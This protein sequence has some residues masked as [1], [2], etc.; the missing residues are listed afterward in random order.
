MNNCYNYI[1]SEKKRNGSDS[2]SSESDQETK[3]VLEYRKKHQVT[4][5]KGLGMYVLKIE[6]LVNQQRQTQCQRKNISN[7][8]NHCYSLCWNNLLNHH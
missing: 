6:N 3:I 7:T 2:D 8:A 1:V 4:C 5:K